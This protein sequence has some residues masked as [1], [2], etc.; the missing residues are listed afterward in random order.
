[1]KIK[2][3]KKEK[4]FI[5]IIA[6]LII[7]NI[8]LFINRPQSEKENPGVP[9]YNDVTISE[10]KEIT[11][12]PG[13]D[14]EIL[15]Y[16]YNAKER[17]RMEFY[18]GSYLKCLDEKDYQKA[19]EMI[20]PEFKEKYFPTYSKFEEYIKKTYPSELA[21]EVDDI[22]RY[23]N[24]YVLRVKLVDMLGEKPEQDRFQRFVIRENDFNK[25]D[26]SFQVI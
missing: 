23:N 5:I 18:L 14:D 11:K 15:E 4:I 3:D 21:I 19:Y 12:N 24:M 17:D 7:T 25:F 22:T 16:L 9:I 1:M 20:Y 8:I 13:T 26:L 6:I 2:L 10:Q